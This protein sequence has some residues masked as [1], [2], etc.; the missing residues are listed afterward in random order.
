MCV[1]NLEPLKTSDDKGGAYVK[2]M[3]NNIIFYPRVYEMLA[4]SP[5]F[6]DPF[7]F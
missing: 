4:L 3:K 2:K 6:F 1:E 5:I 7:T